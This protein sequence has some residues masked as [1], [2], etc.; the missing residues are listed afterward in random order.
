MEDLEALLRD[1]SPESWREYGKALLNGGD[2]KRRPEGLAAILRAYGAK[3]AEAA[4]LVGTLMLEGAMR[5][6]QG[7]PEERALEI[8][9]KA[10]AAGEVQ[11][12]ARLNAYCAERYERIIGSSPTRTPLGPLTDFRGKRI[13]I[14]RTGLLTPVDA[15]LTWENGMNHLALSANLCFLSLEDVPDPR[16]LRAAVMD[17]IA[18]WEGEYRVFNDQPLRVSVSLTTEDRLL[19]SVIVLP[20]TEDTASVF[21]RVSGVS[22]KKKRERLRSVLE[23]RRSFAALGRKWSTRSVKLICL[24]SDNGRFD[25]YEE[26]MHVAKHEFGHALGLGDLYGSATDELRGVEK[27]TYPEIDGYYISDKL[28]NLVMCDHHGPIGNNDLEMVLLAFSEDKMQL[29]Q[30][31]GGVRGGVSEALGKGN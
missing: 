26:I 25:D 9:R 13:R 27:G 24:Q 11:A 23:E 2:P 7:D 19:D 22:P 15:V 4:Y 3:D 30:E 20:V 21:R 28:Y 14:N 31:G 29:Y 18:L 17:G 8:L 6:V 12:R 16:R 1:D 10:S 5:P